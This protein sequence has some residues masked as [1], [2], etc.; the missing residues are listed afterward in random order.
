MS[1]RP[2]SEVF[3]DEGPKQPVR[4]GKKHSLDSDEEDNGAEEE[5][6]NVMNADDIEGEEEGVGG[7]EGEITITPFN[8][9][10]ELEEGHFDA[11]GHYQW[12]KQ[13]EIKDG[14]LDNID[15]VKVKGRP[16][17]KYKIHKSEDN[18]G[19]GDESS[20]EDEEIN[21]KFDLIENYKEILQHMKP[22]E[23][24]AKALQR[25]GASSKIS[26]AERWKRKKAGI[27]DE[28]SKIVTRITELA[29]QILTK[30]GNMDI[31]QE[32]YEKINGIVSKASNE[33]ADLDMYADDFDQKE[34][35]NLE[36]KNPDPTPFETK[37]EEKNTNEVKWEFKW[38]QNDDD[39]SGPH[40]TEQMNK[41]ASEGYFKSGV[42][43]K[44]Q[45]E[46]SQFYNS[47]RIDFELYM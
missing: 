31:Y 8:M 42:W 36:S 29:N 23:T 33:D 26:S 20:S 13:T 11:Q 37:T 1:K 24:I 34:K 21:E 43:V 4:E 35:Q 46:D 9:K 32:N 14:W 27:I 47:N 6:N 12:K 22:R 25:L 18:K 44:K 10:E 28:N 2:A 5:R 17:D 30:M 19:L 3:D 45:G 41:W 15:W 38:S 40:S 16:E 39:V 7:I